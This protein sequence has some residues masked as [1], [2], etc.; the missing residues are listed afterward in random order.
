[1]RFFFNF[2]N[3]FPSWEPDRDSTP[4]LAGYRLGH[5]AS[6]WF[7]PWRMLKSQRKVLP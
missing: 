2:I 4:R 3:D 6:R 7:R 5:C 1:L